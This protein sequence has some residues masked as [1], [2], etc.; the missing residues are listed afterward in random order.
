MLKEYYIDRIG[1]ISV[2]GSVVSMDMSR[3]VSSDENENNINYEKK[4]TVTMTGQNFLNMVNMLNNTV[5]TISERQKESKK[6]GAKSPS[7]NT[8]EKSLE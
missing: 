5:K 3:M 1:N 2:Q 8:K 6:N 4:L 7:N